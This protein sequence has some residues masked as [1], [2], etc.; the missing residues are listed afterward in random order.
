MEIQ[1]AEIMF[2][3]IFA[4]AVIIWG[5]SL[6]MASRIGKQ[7]VDDDDSTNWQEPK[8][9]PFDSETPS[10]NVRGTE[11]IDCQ[12]AADAIQKLAKKA[13][14]GMGNANV[15]NQYRIEKPAQNKLRVSSTTPAGINKAMMLYFD[16]AEFE[17][18]ARGSQNIEIE[19]RLSFDRLAKKTRRISLW[20]ILALGLPVMLFGFTAIWFFVVQNENPAIRWQVFQSL[21]ICHVLW[22]PFL[23][24]GLY[25]A[26]IRNAKN[27]VPNLLR[28]L[29]F[30]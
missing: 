9:N 14:E 7:T 2:F 19:Y 11:T 12:S 26:A 4:I 16:E 6:R 29:A 22:P 1:F 25:K 13:A 20:I 28:S 21:Q 3:V 23:F 27:T 18:N 5:I 15:A 10:W 30:Q 17:A 24:L 8:T